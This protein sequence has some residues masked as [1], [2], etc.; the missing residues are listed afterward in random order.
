MNMEKPFALALFG[1]RYIE[2]VRDLEKRL[3]TALTDIFTSHSCVEIYV[4]R[5]GD[6]DEIAAS[7]IKQMKKKYHENEI[8]LILTL[9]YTVKDIEYYEK[10]YDE[11]IIPESI[12]KAHYKKA[13][14]RRNEWM[15][16]GSDAVIVYVERKSGGAYTAM[17]YAEKQ[18]KRILN[19]KSENT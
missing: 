12:G 19:L 11:I 6:F 7:V 1:H 10:Y 3:E 13:I 15:V 14:T 16:E 9:A 8:I 5:N 17:R 4:G 2:D 18:G